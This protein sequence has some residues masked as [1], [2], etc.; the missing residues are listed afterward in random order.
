[1]TDRDGG[2]I[3]VRDVARARSGDKADVLN[4][5]VIADDEVSYRR[6][7]DQL[8]AD[9][10]AD[11]LDGLVDGD[12]RRYRMPNV[13]AFNFV[14]TGAL[15][16]GGQASIRYDTQGKTYAA[17]VLLTE[18]PAWNGDER[19]GGEERDGENEHGGRNADESTAGGEHR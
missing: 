13:R 4:V 8:T 11:R 16:G 7:D 10:V 17:I 3:R 1:M 14:A 9:R 18:L 19:D 12:V 6:L 5:G 15:D 2:S